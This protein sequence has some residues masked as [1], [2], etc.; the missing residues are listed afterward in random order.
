MQFFTADR[1]A[2][3]STAILL[4]NLEGFAKQ[5]ANTNVRE[6]QIRNAN[7]IALIKAELQKRAA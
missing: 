1:I 6:F 7:V 5:Q 4:D 3:L 2:T